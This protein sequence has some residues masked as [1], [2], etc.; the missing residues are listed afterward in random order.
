MHNSTLPT[1]N[2]PFQ[3]VDQVVL[4]GLPASAVQGMK[5]QRADELFC[6]SQQA[7]WRSTD[8]WFARLMIFQW[9]AAIVVALTVSPRTWAGV[10]SNVH[11]H[12]WLA[13]LMGGAITSFP[14][15]LA[16]Q[17]P[18]RNYTR[19]LIAV[20]Q[21]LMSSLLIHL[22]GGRIET[23]FHIFGSLAFL[24]FYRDWRVLIPASIVVVLDH[25]LRGHF[26]PQSI[27]GVPWASP[28]RVWEHAGWV[29]FEDIFLIAACIRGAREMREIGQHRAE[30][31]ITNR[32][33]EAEVVERTA[34]TLESEERFLAMASTVPGM[35]YQLT[36]SRDGS[37]KFAFVS[38]GGRDLFQIEPAAMVQSPDRLLSLI[39]SDDRTRFVATLTS[40]AMTLEPWKWEGRIIQPSGD[41]KW[42]RGVA[43]PER[44]KDGACRWNGLLIDISESKAMER[45][46]NE[47]ISTVS[48]ELRTP[49]TSIRGS[50]GLIVGGVT[51]DL[52]PKAHTM[53][54]IAYKNSER[55]VRLI[56]DILDIEKIESGKMVLDLQPITL[57]PFA[58]TVLDAN[59]AYGETLG[60][61][62]R[63]ESR[64]LDQESMILAD[65][66]RLMQVFAN[67]LSN[68]AKYSP[69]GGEV[70]VALM[71]HDGAIRVEV[72]DN[73]GG[74]PEEFIGRIFQKFSQADSSDT[75][76]KGGT[77]LGLSISKALV[78]Q[79]QGSI[80]FDTVA[81]VGTTFYFELPQYHPVS[82]GELLPDSSGKKTQEDHP[83][84][85][86]QPR[87]LICEDDPDIATLLSMMLEQ[88][89]FLTDKAHDAAT[90]KT[91]LAK[92]RYDGMTLDLTLPGQDGIS[93]FRELRSNPATRD[94][95]VAVVS[96]K[97]E[98]GRRELNGDAIGVTNW[99][100]KPIDQDLLIEAV[101]QFGRIETGARPRILHVEDDPDLRH[102]IADVLQSVADVV[103]ATCI[104]DATEKLNQGP[105]DAIILDLGLPDGSGLQLLPL[106]RTKAPGVPVVVFSADDVE[107]EVAQNIAATLVKSQTTN[108]DLLDTIRALLLPRAAVKK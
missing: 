41:E 96:A 103:S 31:E 45:M 20:A 89:G 102:I 10:Q 99:L 90:A 19:Y 21:M 108:G 81:G 92:T 98:Q 23:H 93:F 74:I 9:V 91:M 79:M 66:D 59:K 105:Y 67:L 11:P 101:Q 29:V 50:L 54:D 39:Q 8:R 82:I 14:V 68:A 71:N 28:W 87:I 32:I 78:E 56:N 88:D 30:L 38:E 94:L 27:F 16:W 47:F 63:L 72:R 5:A 100:N 37:L 34:Q 3:E 86:Y 7:L 60:V 62:F 36:Q 51:G 25:F 13:V 69:R 46:K 1:P 80:G 26:F 24:A 95:P 43:T 77:G 106:L 42:L 84:R 104:S 40:S 2:A 57:L 55:L 4:K 18:G 12:V 48:H 44:L 33:I 70:V 75:R 61:S 22:T 76:Q 58:H 65:S 85:L 64:N 49:L 17:H 107:R 97:S 83:A 73:G 35:V 15:W 6:E 52:P 53:I